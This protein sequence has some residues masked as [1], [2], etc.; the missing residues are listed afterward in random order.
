MVRDGSAEVVAGETEESMARQHSEMQKTTE[1]V[2][3]GASHDD[4]L[5]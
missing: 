4:W 5:Q 1:Y 3:V 2:G